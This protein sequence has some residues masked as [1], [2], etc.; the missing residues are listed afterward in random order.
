MQLT[1]EFRNFGSVSS[2]LLT[3]K[4]GLLRCHR[5]RMDRVVHMTV[6][7]RLPGM[8][9]EAVSSTTLKSCTLVAAGQAYYHRFPREITT[10]GI[11]P[12][13]AVGLCLVG[14]QNIG[15]FF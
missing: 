9:L 15:H 2:L 14:A 12:T 3:G 8:R 11:P 10:S 13:V 4:A 6:R 1:M 5:Q 7:M